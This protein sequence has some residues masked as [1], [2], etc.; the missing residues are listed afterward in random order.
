MC[1]FL[2]VMQGVVVLGGRRVGLAR[3]RR[4][5]ELSQEE[6]GRRLPADPTSIRDWEAGRSEP[7]PFKRGKL[8][9]LLQVT[10][11][12]LEELLQEGTAGAEPTTGL[13]TTAAQPLPDYVSPGYA[14]SL[15]RTLG[16]LTAMANADQQGIAASQIGPFAVD[17]PAEVVLAWLF[18]A[19]DD[20]VTPVGR[21]VSMLDVDEIV[22]TTKTLDGLDRQFGGG[23]ARGLAVKYLVDRVLP[24]LRCPASPSVR[25]ELLQAAAVLCEVIGYMA[26]DGQLHA[27]AQRYFVQSLRLAKEAG[28]PAYGSFVLATMSHQALYRER[29]DQALILARAAQQGAP[30]V[31]VPAVATEAAMLE[32]TASAAMG[33]RVASI[34]ALTR[35][36]SSFQRHGPESEAPYW[37]AHWDESVFA[38][39]AS[40]AW[41]DL[42]EQ[43][44]AEPYLQML[45]VGAR[46]QVRRQVFAAGQLARVALLER[47]IERSAHYGTM[48]VEAA[49]A[50]KSKRSHRI[51]R[52]LLTQLDGYRQLPPV[53]ELTDR[54]TALLPSE[55][56]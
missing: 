10:P 33:D 22:T 38:S 54:V 49:A 44:K 12:Q 36:E 37:M 29:P 53:R 26:Y 40:T 9:K 1:R 55:A 4:A 11:A 24:Q 46:Q 25:R 16:A 45:W 5:A 23:F 30:S 51:V 32:A 7:L 20:D 43:T 35:A 3:A 21:P 27:L 34:Q 48:A 31:S 42:G 18:G 39:F 8:A 6:L 17:F 50:A 56:P 19:T 14:M 52:D 28:N 47:D 2:G 41:L 13:A 15:E